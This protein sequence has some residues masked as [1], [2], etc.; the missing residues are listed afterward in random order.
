MV[1]RAQIG[2]SP[3]VGLLVLGLRLFSGIILLGHVVDTA[4]VPLPIGVD[5][6]SSIASAR[7]T[8]SLHMPLFLAVVAYDV[9][10]AGPVAADWGGV[11]GGAGVAAGVLVVG[12]VVPA[13]GSDLFDLLQ[14]QVVPGDV[15]GLGQRH[16]GLDRGDSLA[17]LMIL[18]LIHI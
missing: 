2:N 3:D 7:V 4:L 14:S 16:A 18:S 15:D 10:V 8:F 13:D 11:H 12:R 5:H 6:G 9:R 1:I 17:A